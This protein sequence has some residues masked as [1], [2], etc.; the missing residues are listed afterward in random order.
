MSGLPLAIKAAVAA[1]MV[2]SIWRALYGPPPEHRD[3]T[4]ARLWGLTA[5]ILYVSG[6]VALADGRAGA[7]LLLIAGVVALCMAFWHAR[8][9][10]G[11][12]GGGDP[13]DDDTGP[14]DWDQ[15]DRAR[16]EWDQPRVPA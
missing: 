6:I 7:W 4:V 5:F 11:G 10:D 2:V 14:I 3:L 16:R 13:G 15:F 1:V 9:D 8:G 12:G